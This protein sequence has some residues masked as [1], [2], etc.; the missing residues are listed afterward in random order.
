MEKM[1]TFGDCAAEDDNPPWHWEEP[2]D[3]ESYQ[4]MPCMV[5]CMSLA[6]MIYIKTNRFQQT[7]QS[8][9]DWLTIKAQLCGTATW[10]YVLPWLGG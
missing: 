9:G 10:N 3:D 4:L 7:M 6:V 1:S 5:C 2:D 8:V